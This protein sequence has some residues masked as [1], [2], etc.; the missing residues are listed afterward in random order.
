MADTDQTVV[1]TPG[2]DDAD[3]RAT[4]SVSPTAPLPPLVA[5]GSATETS[6]MD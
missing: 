4:V 5:S 6:D 2:P 1:P 3:R